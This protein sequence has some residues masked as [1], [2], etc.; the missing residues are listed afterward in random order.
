MLR[1]LL[2]KLRQPKNPPGKGD[3]IACIQFGSALLQTQIGGKDGVSL[4]SRLHVVKKVF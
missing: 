4:R 1:H 2:A 3:Q